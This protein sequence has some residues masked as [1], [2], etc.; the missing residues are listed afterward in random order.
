SDETPVVRRWATRRNAIVAAAL[1]AAVAVLVWIAVAPGASSSRN[2]RGRP[3]T[4]VGTA[5][6]VTADVPVTLPAI[7]TV[8]P[9]A[10]ATVRTQLAGQL[11]HL[12]FTEGQM[13]KQGD[14]VAEI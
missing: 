1:V 3:P 10:T 13:V 12:Y 5:K 8:V 9:L 7:G 6:V 4:T 2:M 14:L 11:T